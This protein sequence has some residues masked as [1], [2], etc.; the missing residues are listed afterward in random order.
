MPQCSRRHNNRSNNRVFKIPMTYATRKKYAIDPVN[1]TPI[2]TATPTPRARVCTGRQCDSRCADSASPGGTLAPH[3][4]AAGQ[5][6][7][8]DPFD[9]REPGGC[10]VVLISR[11]NLVRFDG[12]DI[13]SSVGVERRFQLFLTDGVG[14]S[15]GT[16]VTEAQHIQGS[17]VLGHRP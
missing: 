3:R 13:P 5:S 1:W 8:L 17:I 7:S 16:I 11:L 14:A 4:G 6:H 15:I 2:S 9:C 12:G 10:A